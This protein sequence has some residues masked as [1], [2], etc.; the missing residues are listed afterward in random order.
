MCLHTAFAIHGHM[1]TLDLLDRS[2]NARTHTTHT[3]SRPV[4]S[5]SAAH[6]HI[7]LVLPSPP[8]PVPYLPRAPPPP[9]CTHPQDDSV[10]STYWPSALQVGD[11]LGDVEA[12][13]DYSFGNFKMN[14][15]SVSQRS[16]VHQGQG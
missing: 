1:H 12:V 2:R 15:L 7:Q 14:V 13:V 5:R 9:P 6:I 16:C 8:R 10:K 11:V 4:R 3:S